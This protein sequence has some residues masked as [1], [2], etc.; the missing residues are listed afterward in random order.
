MTIASIISFAVYKGN[1][2]E[3]MPQIRKITRFGILVI[4][5]TFLNI[6]FSAF[7]Y[8]IQ[9][10]MS[11]VPSFAMSSRAA[12]GVMIGI[13]VLFCIGILIHFYKTYNSDVL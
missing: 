5:I 6:L 3:E 12:A 7:S 8:L 10:S 1:D 2:L 4:H 13:V 9:P 11:T